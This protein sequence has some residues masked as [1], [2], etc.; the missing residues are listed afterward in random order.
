MRTSLTVKQE[1]EEDRATLILHDGATQESVVLSAKQLRIV[2]ALFER[3]GPEG[4]VEVTIEL[5]ADGT[6]RL[7]LDDGQP[8]T[9]Q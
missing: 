3:A 5:Q 7:T 2:R 4:L 6:S 9:I 8:E 1:P